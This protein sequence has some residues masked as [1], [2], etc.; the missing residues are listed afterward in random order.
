MD[1]VKNVYFHFRFQKH[2]GGMTM[3]H[4]GLE[5]V[6]KMYQRTNRNLPKWLIVLTDGDSS[7]G[8]SSLKQPIK[9]LKGMGTRI[10]SVGVGQSVGE[11][12]LMEM[13]TDQHHV[14]KVYTDTD[15]S[16]YAQRFFHILCE[17]K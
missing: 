11:R 7:N 5:E 15:V 3:T 16:K 2:S 1:S 6:I 17:G 13:A 4:I 8:V 9:T 12:E 10:I 14:F